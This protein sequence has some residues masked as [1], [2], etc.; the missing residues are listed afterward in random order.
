MKRVDDS[1]QRPSLPCE[2][3]FFFGMRRGAL[4]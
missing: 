4:A 2:G 1:L 3:R